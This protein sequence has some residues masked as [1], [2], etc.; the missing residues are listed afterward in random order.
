MSATFIR[1]SIKTDLWT[2]IE[3][4]LPDKITG[5]ALLFRIIREHQAQGATVL[6]NLEDKLRKL[7][8]SEEP[9]DDVITHSNKVT[10]IACRIVGSR[11]APRNLN[12]LVANTYQNSTTKHFEL[13]A[14][15]IINDID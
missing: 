5:P 13:E 2:K 9:G 3:R 6:R 11:S 8:L 12:L 14:L 7:K 1:E 15:R 10:E 4:T